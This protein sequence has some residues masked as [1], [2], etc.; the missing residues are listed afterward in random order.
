MGHVGLEG[1]GKSAAVRVAAL[2]GERH[3][4][5]LRKPKSVHPRLGEG[6]ARCEARC[7]I[8]GKAPPHRP[9]PGG[10][11]KNVA[12][13]ISGD[14]RRF[15]R[16]VQRIS[17]ASTDRAVP[18]DLAVRFDGSRFPEKVHRRCHRGP[19]S[20]WKRQ[21]VPA[22][23]SYGGSERLPGLSEEPAAQRSYLEGVQEK[24]VGEATG[25]HRCVQRQA[26]LLQLNKPKKHE[27]Q[28][29][30]QKNVFLYCARGGP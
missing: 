10:G 9:L 25:S 30:R 24:T 14:R 20:V 23:H 22:D 21:E 6:V 29:L 26:Q 4:G 1:K 13:E 11:S 8:R 19:R 17:F 27:L 2:P 18:R 16:L 28:L 15:H 5:A 7:E 12:P 3:G